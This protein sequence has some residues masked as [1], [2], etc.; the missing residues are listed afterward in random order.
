MIV[1]VINS[2]TRGE[3]TDAILALAQLLHRDADADRVEAQGPY[4]PR[5]EPA[6][7]TESAACSICLEPHGRAGSVKALCGHCFHDTCI[8]RWAERARTCPMCRSD[9]VDE[10]DV[11]L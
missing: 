7:F 6:L 9:L 10:T 4:F 5:T 8:T 3:L 2:H 11:D 1:I